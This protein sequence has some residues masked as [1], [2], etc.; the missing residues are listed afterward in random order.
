M[1]RPLIACAQLNPITGDLDSN[2]RNIIDMAQAAF[3]ADAQVLLTSAYSLPG[4]PLGAWGLRRDFLQAQQDRL[5]AIANASRGFSPLTIVIGI[6]ADNGQSSLAIIHDGKL[7]DS[8]VCGQTRTIPTAR[9]NLLLA[10]SEDVFSG[11]VTQQT[12][13]NA[14]AV[15]VLVST[16]RTYL[17]GETERF[18]DE[19]KRTA[20]RLR[21]PVVVVNRVGA[22]DDVIYLGGSTAADASGET[23]MA[24]PWLS[25]G[26]AYVGC[27]Q[28][29]AREKPKHI[30]ILYD[31]LVVAV[32]D[33]VHKN[34]FSSVEL[35]LSGGVDSALVAAI[36]ADAVGA[37]N[38]WTVMMPTRFTAELSLR[39]A[40]KLAQNLGVHYEVR[41]IEPLFKAYMNELAHDFAGQVWNETEE[42]LQARIRGN[43][44]MAYANKFG[45]F[46]LA[47]GNKSES[48][49]GYSTLYGDTA[50][51][52]A[53]IK[54]VFK[55]EVW[56][57]C[58]EVN[59]RAGFERIP[60]SIIARAPSAELREGQ[61]DEASLPAYAV[62]DA[63]L[64][65]YIELGHTPREI[66]AAG[67][68]VDTVER[69]VGMVHRNEYK[70]R[71]CP[72]GP[73][74]SLR[75]LGVDWEYPMSMSIHYMKESANITI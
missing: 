37:E 70:R 5:L 55:T 30:E 36:A 50:G 35:G 69:I 66:I 51:A 18:E 13:S 29:I 47:T 2:S 59:R 8:V 14:H 33:Y 46:V 32:R 9:G 75:S 60:E 34:G 1:D 65:R 22:Q 53:P 56:E 67:F 16:A 28:S 27:G 58:R 15:C 61:I 25:T 72:V 11:V 48:A 19:I 42:N 24:M 26:L 57:L 7:V 68:D 17:N 4:C 6:V 31:A 3:K 71:Q 74:V 49:V 21:C 40:K 23:I 73:R 20:K 39:E 12:V 62:L 43:L 45:R 38:V 64:M 52:Y 54:D 10:T 63:I 41:V 44:L